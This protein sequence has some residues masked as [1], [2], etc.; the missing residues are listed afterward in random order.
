M[1]RFAEGRQTAL[2]TAVQNYSHQHTPLPGAATVARRKALVTQIIE[3]LR[4]VEFVKRIAIRPIDIRRCD[5]ATVM[6]DP[7]RAALLHFHDG[8]LDEAI[9][10][11]FLATHFGKHLRDGWRLLRDVYRGDGAPWTFARVANDPDAFEGWLGDAY[12]WLK[13]DGISRRF[14]NHRKYETL[15]IDAARGTSNVIRSY[16]TWV[17]ANRGHAGLISDTLAVSGKDAKA[18]FDELYR[19]MDAVISFGRTGR[20]DFLTMIGKLGLADIE[21][22]IPYLIDATGPLDGARLLFGNGKDAR[23][24]PDDLDNRVAALGAYLGVGMQVMEDSLCNWQKSPDKFAAF[25]G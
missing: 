14:G 24:R 1:G 3:S 25:R 19:S 12:E 20:F 9:W 8:D 21:P 18:L 23:L 11:V 22:G 2:L 7:L 15:R 10:L 17:G 6:F 5:P 13:H 4:R 16:L